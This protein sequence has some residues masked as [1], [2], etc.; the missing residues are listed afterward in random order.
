MFYLFLTAE[1][2]VKLVAHSTAHFTFM[3]CVECYAIASIPNYTIYLLIREFEL[4]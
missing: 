3:M 4:I 2:S 1:A